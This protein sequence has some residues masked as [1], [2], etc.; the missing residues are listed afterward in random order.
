MPSAS[1]NLEAHLDRRPP[2]PNPLPEVGTP[3]W[4]AW[5]RPYVKWVEEKFQLEFLRDHGRR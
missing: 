5:Y 4:Q 1:S 3:E 2:R